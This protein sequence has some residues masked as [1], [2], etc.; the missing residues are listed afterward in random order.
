MNK[1]EQNLVTVFFDIRVKEITTFV[2]TATEMELKFAVK[3]NKAY[4]KYTQA[5]IT[6]HSLREVY[7]FGYNFASQ[8]VKE[9][10]VYRYVPEIR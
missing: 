1:K 4:A 6:A 9:K 8:V 7:Y 5:S 2:R 10:V 3:H